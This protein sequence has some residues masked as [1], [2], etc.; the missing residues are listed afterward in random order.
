MLTGSIRNL[1][2][3]GAAH[4]NHCPLKF[5]YGLFVAINLPSERIS[6]LPLIIPSLLEYGIFLH[7]LIKG[8]SQ[9]LDPPNQFL[10][11]LLDVTWGMSRHKSPLQRFSLFR[12]ETLRFREFVI[13]LDTKCIQLLDV[14]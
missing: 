12:E 11:F 13:I 14:R 9:L 4:L 1:S 7:Y 2:Y 10:V 3:V 5:S 8:I 6:K